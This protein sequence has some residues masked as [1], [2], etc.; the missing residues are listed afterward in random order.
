[1]LERRRQADGGFREDETS[2]KTSAG[3]EM[4]DWAGDKQK[5]LGEDPAG[6]GGAGADARRRRRKSVAS[7][8]KRNQQR[9]SEGP[10]RSR[11]KPAAP[12][13]DQPDPKAQRN[14]TDPESRIMSPKDA[15][16]RPIMHRPPSTQAP[17]SCSAHELTSA[18]TDQGQLVPLVE[19]I[20]K[21][22]RPEAG[23]GLSGLPGY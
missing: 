13:S 3:D 17:R 4:P 16:F 8:S 22:S 18:A 15:L 20:E 11:G 5:R 23:A 2:A 12:P 6:D 21:Q 14:F 9:Q 7:R 19:A 10:Q 1:M